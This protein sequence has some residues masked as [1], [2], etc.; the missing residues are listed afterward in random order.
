MPPKVK[1]ISRKKAA[2][3]GHRTTVKRIAY[4]VSEQVDGSWSDVSVDENK[5][6]LALLVSKLH[7]Q[8]QSLHVKLETLNV[9][10]N[11]VNRGRR[12]NGR[13]NSGSRSR[14]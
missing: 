7:Q 4:A 8:R 11:L 5:Q 9:V 13:R 1:A 12:G 2:R 3:E 10:D 6:A 14:K